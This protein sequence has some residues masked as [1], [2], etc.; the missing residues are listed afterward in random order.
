M[1]MAVVLAISH[2]QAVAR[3][4]HMTEEA[5]LR[6][7]EGARFAIHQQLNGVAPPPGLLVTATSANVT[8]PGNPVLKPEMAKGIFDRKAG[9]PDLRSL[10][11]SPANNVLKLTPTSSDVALR[12]FGSNTYTAVITNVPGYAAYAPAGSVNITN[13]ES[14]ANPTF[15]DPRKT[16]E[17]YSGVM[18]IVA[19]KNDATI[20]NVTYGEA[21]VISG[22]AKIDHGNGITYKK[23]NLPLPAYEAQIIDEIKKARDRMIEVGASGDKTKQVYS[24]G[25]TPGSIVSLFFGGEAGLE[26]FLSLGNANHFFL[27]MV[28]FFSPAP[29]YLYC[30]AFHMPFP[31]DTAS[32]ASNSDAA[33]ELQNLAEPMKKATEKRDAADAAKK[34]AQQAY[35]QDPSADNLAALNA[36]STA[37]NAAQS[38][39]D[40]LFSKAQALAG[41]IKASMDTQIASSQPRG[42]PLTRSQDPEGNDGVTGWSYSSAVEAFAKAVGMVVLLDFDFEKLAQATGNP[43]VKLIHF[44]SKDREFKFDLSA[45]NMGIDATVTVPRGRVLKL[46]SPNITIAGDLWL[47]RG[48]TFYA[49][50]DNLT[51]SAGRGSD[52]SKFFSPSGRIF[53]EEGSSLVCRGTVNC[54]GSS[55]WGSVIVG[56]V[57]GKIH[58]ITTSIMAKQVNLGNGVFAGCAIDDLVEGLGDMLDS[59]T[60]KDLNNQLMRPLLA[61]VAPNAAKAFGPFFARR[62]YFAKYATTFQIIFPP[63][64]FFGA[65]S[66]IPIPTPIPLPIK[67]CHVGIARALGYV[68][69]V[70]LNLGLGENFYTHCDWWIFGEGVVPMVPQA[71]PTKLAE[72]FTNFGTT[73]LDAL[74]PATIVGNFIESAVKD[75]VGY[76]VGEVIKQV[77]AKIALAVTPYLGLTDIASTLLDEVASNLTNR[78]ASKDTAGDALT[79]SLTSAIASAGKNSLDNLASAFSLSLQDQFLREYNGVLVYAEDNIQVGG[80]NAT[81]M[82]VAGKDIRITASQCTGTLLSQTGNVQCDRLLFYPYFNQASIYVPKSGPDGWLNRGKEFLYDKDYASNEAKDVGPPKIP[83]IISAQGWAQ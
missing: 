81:G 20:A 38:E 68:Y 2:F 48:S 62:P 17:A 5:S 8:A 31:A 19:A 57:P 35:N 67:N 32:Y 64:P 12:V 60:L 74:D 21:H 10:E 70:S 13:M 22:N 59:N 78:F 56:G 7:R 51:I 71:D 76:V 40:D 63:T 49:D 1:L 65:P 53:M 55:Q 73:A 4:T 34:A 47:Q 15:K 45:T 28:P 82:F 52:S 61:N 46:S 41:P 39:L 3:Q 43:D 58:P 9:L 33:A 42:V 11:S 26:Q 69:S 54:V 24:G 23:K 36:A 79:G 72:K 29:P 14:W 75:M 37:L 80:K 18:A 44:G 77:V 66:P 30:L 27:P 16:L 25:L 50:C 83:A 6:F